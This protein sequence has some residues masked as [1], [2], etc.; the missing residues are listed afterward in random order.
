[1]TAHERG[2]EELLGALGELQRAQRAELD[3]FELPAREL[4][5]REPERVQAFEARLLRELAAPHVVAKA[6]PQRMGRVVSIAAASCAIAAAALLWVRAPAE[7]EL[8]YT[9][10]PPTADA[11]TRAAQPTAA[12]GS[13]TLGRTLSF[14]L[15]PTLR[16]SGPLH[17]SAYAAKDGVLVE[18]HPQV[19]LDPAGGAHVTVATGP[20]S[21][22]T[23]AGSW[24]LQFRVSPESVAA[25]SD[26]GSCPA[27][28]RCLTYRARFVHPQGL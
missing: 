10:V 20:G 15:R 22:L 26:A 1:M 14:A 11:V 9:L 5:A 25:V 6:K 24:E 8:Q 23:S 19:E 7:F 28:T 17:V 12:G 27:N 13:Y 3:R 21:Q 2:A 16:H 18:L 4:A